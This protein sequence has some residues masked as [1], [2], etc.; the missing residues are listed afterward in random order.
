MTESIQELLE[1]I[2]QEGIQAAEDKAQQ[3][4]NS[5][6]QHAESLLTQAKDLVDKTNQDAKDKLLKFEEKQKALLVQAARDLLLSLRKEINIMLD[7]VILLEVEKT[8]TPE[9]LS[10]ILIALTKEHLEK[11]DI[12]ITLKKE[13]LVGLEEHILVKL[14]DEAKKGITLKSS[15]EIKGGFVIS[16]DKD[17][18]HFDFTDKALAEYIASHIKPKLNEIL[19]QA[20]KK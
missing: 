20:I 19:N 10:R 12:V 5:A 2:N 13:D 14:K 4:E 6:R 16:F 15:S 9:N 7:K 1:K 11:K 17:K 18:S 8:L 3:I